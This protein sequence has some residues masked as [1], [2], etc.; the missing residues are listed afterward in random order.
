MPLEPVLEPAAQEFADATAEPPFLYELPVEEGRAQFDEVQSGDIAKPSVEIEDRVV[1]GGPSGQIPIRIVRPRA[2]AG[3]LPVIQYNH[4]AGWVFGDAD[5]YDRLIRELAVGSNAAV[6]FPSFTRS[7]EAKYPTAIEELYATSIWIA[8]HGTDADLDP[9]RIA[10]AGDSVGGNMTIALTL[11]AKQRGG[12]QFRHQVLFYPVTNAEF[13]TDSYRQFAHGYFLTVEAM[14]WFWDQYTTDPAHRA[15]ITCSPLR[16]TTEQL[17]GLPP[18][19]VI[20]GEAD[21]LRDEGEAYANKLRAAGVPVTAVR[22]QGMIHDFMML[23]A[24]ADTH[25]ARTALLLATTA[26]ERALYG[27]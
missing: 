14:R 24:L 11:L 1:D 4:G 22:F 27:A 5:I 10:V 15:E 20:N 13:D 7:P 3:P 2:A 21:V 23:N 17:A 18:A 26:L 6:A 9:T 8:D 25:A 19:L 12:P 16:A